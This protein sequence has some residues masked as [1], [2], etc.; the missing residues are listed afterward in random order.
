MSV[1]FDVCHIPIGWL[2]DFAPSNI[3][4]MLVTLEVSH[5]VISKYVY[6]ETN[7]G[8]VC[9]VSVMRESYGKNNKYS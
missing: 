4:F 7:R 3:A 5:V 1:T 9:Y 2:N 6:W 8:S